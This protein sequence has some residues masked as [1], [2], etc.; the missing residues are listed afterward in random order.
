MVPYAIQVCF[1]AKG[2]HLIPQCAVAFS[3]SLPLLAEKG[4]LSFCDLEL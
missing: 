1:S 3:I 4:T 2:G